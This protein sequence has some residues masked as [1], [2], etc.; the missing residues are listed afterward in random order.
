MRLSGFGGAQ[1]AEGTLVP[2]HGPE[3]LEEL[4]RRD[5]PVC[6]RGAGRSYGDA[7]FA[8]D[9]LV[10]DFTP[11]NRILNWDSGSGL[12]EAEG[13]ATLEQVWRRTLPEGW[14]LPVVSGT[15][16]VT[17][18]GAL[19]MNIHGKNAFAAGTLGEHIAEITVVSPSGRVTLTP[20]DPDFVNIISSAGLLGAIISA[21]LQMKRVPAAGVRVEP[22]SC[23]TL[24]EQFAAFD[25]DAEYKVSWLDVFGGGRGLF[26][27]AWAAEDGEFRQ[28][29]PSRIFGVVPKDQAWRILRLFN[30]RPAM[31]VLN[32][33]KHFAGTRETTRVQSLAEFNFLLDYVPGWERS[34]APGGLIQTQYFLPLD[35]KSVLGDIIELQRSRALESCLAVLKRH[36]SDNF[37]FLFSHAVDGFSIAFDFKV[38]A[39]NRTEIWSLAEEMMDRVLAA[40]GRSYLAK[41]STMTSAQFATSIGPKAMDR[42]REAKAR[43]DPSSL[44]V[45]GQGRRLKLV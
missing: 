30:N 6:L 45:T 43:L 28:D 21:R 12:I 27:R 11:M 42:Y 40:G 17:L 20:S 19:A 9:A 41:D 36:R 2:I 15:T 5:R 3:D 18:A 39:A 26:H 4:F 37:P 31:R 29:L 10:A 44:L 24:G 22:V 8:A 16:K 35:A 14:W 33:A 34:Y 25:E 32:S 7:N 13:G 23:A 1:A 38:T